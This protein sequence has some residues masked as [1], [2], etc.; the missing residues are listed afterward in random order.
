M[1][2]KTYY[3]SFFGLLFFIIFLRL[4]NLATAP[5]SM[6]ID[7]AGLGLNAWSIANFG[8]DRYGNFMPIC[9]SNF[10]GEQSAFYTYFCALLVKLF[11]L[12][13]YT[14]RLPGVIMGI[15]A[16]VFGSLLLKEKWGNKG[17]FTGMALMGI[18]P[19]FI[20]NARFALDCNAMLGTL[21][22]ALY[23]LAKLLKKV[24]KEPGRGLY[25]YFALT[26]F[27]FG[28][29]L[30]TY[31]IAA[32]VVA[33]FCVLFGLYFLLYHK[34][35]RGLRFRQLL[36]FALPL[37]VM[38]IPL[39]LVVCVNY[40]GL[41]P[42]VT[43]LFSIPKMAINRTEEVAFSLSDLPGKLRGLLH[44]LTSDGK[45]GSSDRYLTMY[46]WSIPF[47]IAGGLFCI[48]ESV[49]SLKAGKLSLDACMLFITLAEGF[50][51]LLCGQYN[52][53]I[54]GIFVALAYFCVSGILHL[55]ALLKQ[56]KLRMAFCGLLTCLYTF[57]FAGFSYEYFF[58]T[59]TDV[60]QVFG[61][62]EEAL[63]LLTEEQRGHD[64]YVLN[65]V[66]EFYLLSN[67]IPPAE[68]AAVCDEL[69]YVKD[70]KNLHF[71][72]SDSY[73]ANHVYVCSKTSGLYHT[74]SNSSVT[75]H[76]YSVYETKYYYVFFTSN[77]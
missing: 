21:T 38:V 67:P 34:E 14:L 47:V 56:G 37:V 23:C 75:G 10:Y 46:L 3:I 43:P 72:E 73:E 32:I 15:V 19:Y 63:L 41:E 28:M 17:L 33:V 13:I 36:F 5:L 60:Y 27:L 7:E 8:T 30:Y 69:G 45:Y 74:L 62:V 70:Y 58:Q 64:I 11:G 71:H 65:E 39:G 12:N 53:H 2:K 76:A 49:Q 18:F 48:K 4:Y 6:H 25:G 51:F 44:T 35:N 31:I 55:A 26:G 68:F 52:Y 22:V 9:P 50:M 61:G 20:M 59:D 24:E 57:S 54:N 40:F 66:G 29:V 16:V 1:K 42:I 77:P